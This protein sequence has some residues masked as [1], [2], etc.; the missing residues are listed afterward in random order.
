MVLTIFFSRDIGSCFAMY[1]FLIELRT[2]KTLYLI[3][4]LLINK[5]LFLSILDRIL[6]L[7]YDNCICCKS[8]Q[9]EVNVSSEMCIVINNRGIYDKKLKDT[10]SYFLS[11]LLFN[12]VFRFYGNVSGNSE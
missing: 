10:L 1:C 6:K 9:L 2:I 3:N 7:K 11:N 4:L 8:N 5:R 12:N